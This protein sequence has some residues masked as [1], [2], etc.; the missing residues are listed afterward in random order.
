MEKYVLGI[1]ETE[2]FSVQEIISVLAVVPRLKRDFFGKSPIDF[3][4]SPFGFGLVIALFSLSAVTAFIHRLLAAERLGRKVR[5][6][7]MCLGTVLFICVI[8]TSWNP[9]VLFCSAL[10]L[11]EALIR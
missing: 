7:L 5:W 11:C 8:A 3:I 9:I 1:G 10:L 6:T 2:S 4:L